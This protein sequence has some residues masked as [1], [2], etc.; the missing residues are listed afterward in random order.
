[1][2]GFALEDTWVH[3]ADLIAVGA[4]GGRDLGRPD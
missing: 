1:V 3:A 2:G 4:V